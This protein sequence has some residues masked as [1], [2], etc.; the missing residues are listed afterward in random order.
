MFE[1]YIRATAEVCYKRESL[2]FTDEEIDIIADGMEHR[3]PEL[4][5]RWKTFE[6]SMLRQDPKDADEVEIKWLGSSFTNEIESMYK[7]DEC[8]YQV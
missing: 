8:I 6:K 4:K 7:D 5:E 1:I 2:P 3:I